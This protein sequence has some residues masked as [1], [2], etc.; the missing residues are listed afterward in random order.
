MTGKAFSIFSIILLGLI[1]A[2]FVFCPVA[3][4]IEPKIGEMRWELVRV[5]SRERPLPILGIHEILRLSIPVN[6][7]QQ[8]IF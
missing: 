6:R 3:Y 1:A 4:S 7:V 2:H 5:E 8:K